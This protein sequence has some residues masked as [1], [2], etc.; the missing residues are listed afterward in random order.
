ALAEMMPPFG[1]LAIQNLKDTSL[2]SLIT[3]SDLTFHAD[4][5][6]NLTLASTPIYTL[7]LLMYFGMALVLMVLI[8]MIERWSRRH[9][10]PAR[11]AH[12]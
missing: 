5:L 10:A 8:R 1:N 3:I 9:L 7:T 4:A 11:G 12:A 6:R 2:V